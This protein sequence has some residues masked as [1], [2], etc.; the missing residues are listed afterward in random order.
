MCYPGA[1]IDFIKDRLKVANESREVILHVGENSIRNRDGTF[2]MTEIL[3][4]K[5]K[6]LLVRAKEIGKKV[7]VSG[8]LPRLGENEEWWSR[9]IGVNESVHMLCESMSCT[10]LY[11]WKDF[12]DIFKLYKKDGVHLNDK[13]VE[14]FAKRMD[15]C[16]SLWQEN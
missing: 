3:L 14:V 8:I 5:Y 13:K 15:E 4:K 16:L 2:E 1:G 10:Y 12:V 9:A 11:V 7:C 6:E